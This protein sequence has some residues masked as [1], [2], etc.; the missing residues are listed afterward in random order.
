MSTLQGMR[1]YHD[2]QFEG[3]RSR[4][5]VQ[6]GAGGDQPADERLS[7]L[8]RRLLEIV[9]APVFHEGRWALCGVRP[10]DP[11]S[12]DLAAWRW[13]LG[14]VLRLVVV[15]LGEVVSEGHVRIDDAFLPAGLSI[16]FE[17]LLDGSGTT[18]AAAT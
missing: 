8:Y 15:N 6:L 9:D 10:L 2:G 16:V 3:Y 1:F 12:A 7:A 17:D 18:G 4:L 11:M 13:T 14:D 5:P